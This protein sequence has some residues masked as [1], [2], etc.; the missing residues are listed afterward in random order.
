MSVIYNEFKQASAAA[1]ID[2]IAYIEFTSPIT[3]A[4][5]QVTIPWDP[6]G[7]LLFT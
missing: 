3:S 6:T 7:I 5:T 1:E 4:A 2:L